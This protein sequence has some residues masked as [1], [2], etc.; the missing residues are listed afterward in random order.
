MQFEHG[1]AVVTGAAAGI[2]LAISKRLAADGLPLAL[3]DRDADA[4]ADAADELRS[5]GAEVLTRA[6]DVASRPDMTS[7]AAEVHSTLGP[8]TFLCNNAGVSGPL[9]ERAWEVTPDEWTRVI[10]INFFGVV[11]GISAFVPA[12]IASGL[13][14]HIVNM[15]SELGL[16]PSAGTVCYAAS[17]HAI[18]ALSK[19]MLL[20]L[21]EADVPIGVTIV[22]PGP[23]ATDLLAKERAH[24]LQRGGIAPERDAVSTKASGKG[25]VRLTAEQVAESTMSGVREGRLY[26]LT[27]ESSVGRAAQ[28]YQDLIAQITEPAR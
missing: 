24:I 12:M 9:T 26:V 4:L 17:K 27:H 22:C 1:V 3:A 14:G 19:S 5:A 7:F 20:Q 8:V 28:H 18:V 21:A 25:F 10:G 23:V 16:L 13:R 2:G 15:A 6:L 11:N